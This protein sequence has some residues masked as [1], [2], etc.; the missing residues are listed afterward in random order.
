MK[1]IILVIV[2]ILGFNNAALSL[3]WDRIENR[4]NVKLPGNTFGYTIGEGHW[5]SKLEEFTN[6]KILNKFIGKGLRQGNK[7]FYNFDN[8][9]YSQQ[10]QKYHYNYYNNRHQ[11]P[12]NYHHILHLVQ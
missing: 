3:S 7:T 10:F 6:C 2:F 4:N 5:G 8:K 12:H 1:K 11:V 9:T